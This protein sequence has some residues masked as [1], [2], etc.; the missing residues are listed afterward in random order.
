MKGIKHLA[1]KICA[2]TVAAGLAMGSCLPAAAADNAYI[3]GTFTFGAHDS[4]QDRTDSYIYTDQFFANSAYETDLHLAIISMQMASASISSLDVDYPQ[5]SK[6]IQNFLT[7]IGFQ[8][9]EVNQYY[10]EKM[11]KNS[12][13]AAVGYKDLGD[14]VLLAIVPRSAGYEQEW[15]G[16]FTV[17]DSGLHAG[18]Q[19]G[20]D[21]VLNFAKE[22][23][24]N[25]SDVFAG[26][27]VKVWTAGYS[28]GAAVA[29]LIGG[30]L[31][32][33]S[34]GY[35]GLDVQP[36]NIYDYTF[37]TPLT[38]ST[39]MNPRAEQYNNI[40]NYYADYDPVAMAPLAAWGFDRYG[41]DEALDV[42]NADTKTK[43]LENL[44]QLNDTVYQAYTTTDDPD[45]YQAMTLGENF[46]VVPDTSRSIT[47]REFLLDRIGY[48][49][50]TTIPD[51]STYANDYEQAISAATA[52]MIGE[53]DNTVA[54]F[55]NGA[56]SSTSIKPLG[57]MLFLYNWVD[58]YVQT[59]GPDT[60]I[61]DNWKEVI[62]TPE[63]EGEGSATGNETVDN[64]LGSDTYQEI[65]GQVTSDEVLS[66]YQATTYGDLLKAYR[67]I[68][69]AYMEQVLRSGLQAIGLTGDALEQH[70]LLQNNVP[71]ALSVV[72]AQALFG[73]EDTIGLN[74]IVNKLNNAA[75][76][77]G[78]SSY[79][80]V[81][82]NEVILSWLRA[83]DN[84]P[85]DPTQQP[86]TYQIT[87]A[88]KW[89]KGSQDGLGL[90]ATAGTIT[91]IKVDGQETAADQYVIGADGRSVVLNASMLET[92]ALG[93][94]NV[95]VLFTDG[96]GSHDF[97]IVEAVKQDPPKKEQ[98]KQNVTKAKDTKKDTKKAPKTG[99]ETNVTL[100]GM[101]AVVFAA[102]VVTTLE[103]R[104]RKRY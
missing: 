97:Q 22:Y 20:R 4:T 60:P 7:Q 77:I 42:H 6:N 95:T 101:L 33:D 8:N 99:D 13:G 86:V 49:T 104:R 78:N 63:G 50:K 62:P 47:Q 2:V 28:R 90:Q 61:E 76:F 93:N 29:N 1:K 19:A 39:D 70:A 10:Q 81:H 24:S 89:T 37:G 3:T 57:V 54:A 64:F 14:T 36:E 102:G 98:P 23:V 82:N 68:A 53:D 25:H 48:L 85:I 11:Q 12:M 41:K 18:F 87:G 66:Q 75:T 103:V 73:T 51:R 26:K 35:I 59:K 100:W 52:L 15:G 58:Q 34:N 32:D 84:D 17:G 38:A 31:V 45:N 5:K 27:T 9:I 67:M 83:M 71:E 21:I 96:E 46:S 72:A 69:G 80:R 44:S 40:H 94:H 74:A 91:G 30:A 55:K 43:M 88:D 56:A 79:M 16:N 65:Y 92:L